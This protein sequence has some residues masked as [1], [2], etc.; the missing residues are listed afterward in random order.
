MGL[1]VEF[2]VLLSS[3]H[4]LAGNT[5]YGNSMNKIDPPAPAFGDDSSD[6]SG[7]QSAI[8]RAERLQNQAAQSGFDWP[9]IMPVLDKLDEELLELRQAIASGDIDAIEDE[10]G[11]VMFVCVNIAR[12]RKLN[13][14]MALRRTNQKFIRRFEYVVEQMKQAGQGMNQ[15]QLAQMETFWQASKA[16]VG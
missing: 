5:Y 11:D 4:T 14:E 6:A 2:S 15:Q 16:V 10:L 13:A 8:H 9:D 12:H 1:L 7:S 3:L